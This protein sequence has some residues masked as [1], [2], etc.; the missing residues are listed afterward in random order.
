MGEA[1]KDGYTPIRVWSLL[2]FFTLVGKKIVLSKDNLCPIPNLSYTVLAK[3]PGED[4]YFLREYRGYTVDQLYW[5]RK[6]LDFSGD[7]PAIENLR[8]Y[9]DD[10][11]VFL[12]LKPENITD[13]QSM[14]RRLWKTQFKEEGQ[15]DYKLYL[16]ILE[17]S[18]KLEDYQEYSRSLTGYKTVCHQYTVRIVE[19]WKQAEK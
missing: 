11:R 18:L 13:T 12:M 2:Q 5:Y 8:R 7:D 19:L 10:G 15:L 1:S 6:D 16:K 4:R 3:Y 17:E 14:L 9:T